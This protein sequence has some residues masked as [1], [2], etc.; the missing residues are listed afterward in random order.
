MAT[1]I[2]LDFVGLNTLVNEP[3]TS[4]TNTI[5]H[6]LSTTASAYV[7]TVTIGDNH[8]VSIPHDDYLVALNIH[9]NGP[10]GTPIFKQLRAANNPLIRYQNRNNI[11]SYVTDQGRIRQSLRNN[12]VVN[13]FRER[14]SKLRQIV[15]T[16]V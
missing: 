2:N 12:A 9:R 14:R 16:P 15:E 10:Y 5:G 8:S 1:T 3:I 13:S 11:F 4:S 6:A 7:N